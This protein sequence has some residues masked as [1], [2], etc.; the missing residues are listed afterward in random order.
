MLPTK[1]V[2]VFVELLE[3]AGITSMSLKGQ[4]WYLIMPFYRPHYGSKM[5]NTHVVLKIESGLGDVW[6]G[7][8]NPVGR[9]RRRIQQRENFSITLESAGTI[10]Y[11]AV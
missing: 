3:G 5:A 9:A 2:T 1:T 6:Q 11:T 7:L 4:V 10:T 8:C